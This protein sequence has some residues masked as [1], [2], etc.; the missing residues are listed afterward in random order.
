MLAES[1]KDSIYFRKG[2]AMV[3]H[4]IMKA[5]RK[6]VRIQVVGD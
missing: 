6:R 4:E 2:E 3:I 1:F 5:I